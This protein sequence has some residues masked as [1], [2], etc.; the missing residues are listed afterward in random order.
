MSLNS[1]SALENV[2]KLVAAVI[3]PAIMMHNT[4]RR[5]QLPIFDDDVSGDRAKTLCI[6]LTPELSW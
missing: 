6:D 3:H 1:G 4:R 2:P 5:L